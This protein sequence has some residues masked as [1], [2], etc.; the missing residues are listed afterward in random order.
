MNK[1][2]KEWELPVKKK[3]WESEWEMEMETERE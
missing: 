1:I 2:K 3:E